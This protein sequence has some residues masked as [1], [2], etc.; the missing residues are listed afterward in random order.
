MTTTI[1]IVGKNSALADGR[2]AKEKSKRTHSKKEQPKQLLVQRGIPKK[3]ERN[4]SCF[5]F[6]LQSLM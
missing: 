6:G 5:S 1:G 4:V 3:E 2:E